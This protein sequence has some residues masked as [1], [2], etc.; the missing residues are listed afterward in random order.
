M[1]K[2]VLLTVLLFN[3]CSSA[4]KSDATTVLDAKSEVDQIT[5][6]VVSYTEDVNPYEVKELAAVLAD[7]VLVNMDDKDDQ[8]L[9]DVKKLEFDWKELKYRDKY[10][11]SVDAV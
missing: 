11:T 7:L 8:F 5:L 3:G 4:P 1:I 6:A 10:I 9:K 2:L